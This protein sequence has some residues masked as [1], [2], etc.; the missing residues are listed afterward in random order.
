M[1][2]KDMSGEPYGSTKNTILQILLELK[3]ANI[4]CFI[5]KKLCYLQTNLNNQ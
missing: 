2:F 4:M 5:I 1:N 3:L